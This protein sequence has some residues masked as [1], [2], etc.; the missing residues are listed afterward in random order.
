MFRT[1]LVPAKQGCRKNESGPEDV[2]SRRKE[3]PEVPQYPESGFLHLNSTDVLWTLTL[4]QEMG[5]R[6][7]YCGWPPASLAF[8]H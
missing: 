3:H 1:M 5:E 4:L 8:T 7:M 2:G 6:S